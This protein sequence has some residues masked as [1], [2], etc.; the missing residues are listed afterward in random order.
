MSEELLV[1][2]GFSWDDWNGAGSQGAPEL[3]IGL[4]SDEFGICCKELKSIVSDQSGT[5]QRSYALAPVLSS[6]HG[7]SLSCIRVCASRAHLGICKVLQGE[8]VHDACIDVLYRAA[9]FG[10][11]YIL[12]PGNVVVLHQLLYELETG[13]AFRHERGYHD[14]LACLLSDLSKAHFHELGGVAP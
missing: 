2:K 9:C 8:E 5:L 1:S 14:G 11:C 12:F 13:L 7:F 4:A 3:V 10:I 6:A